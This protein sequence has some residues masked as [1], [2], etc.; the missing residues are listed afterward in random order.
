HT[1]SLEDYLW[2]EMKE[3]KHDN[4]K[5]LFEFYGDHATRDKNKQ[6]PIINFNVID[7][8][9]E[10]FGYINIATL[11][12]QK[13]IHLRT[14]CACNPG[15]C[16]DYLNIPSDLI[17]ET[18]ANVLKSTH[19]QKL[20]IVNGRPIGSIRISFG[21]ISTF[22]DAEIVYNFFT[23][24]FRN[25]NVQQFLDEMDLTQKQYINEENEKKQFEKE[26]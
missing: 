26:V 16:Y 1:F 12:T 20:D 15:A 14:G 17:K 11:A 19:K 21:Y 25:K 5:P 23:N 2:N 7:K 8:N 22:E 4:G 24:T 13:N 18:A 10:Y 3:V 6:G 9:G